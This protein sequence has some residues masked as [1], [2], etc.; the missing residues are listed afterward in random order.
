MQGS[1]PDETTPRQAARL[2]AESEGGQPL[3]E[4]EQAIRRAES[5]VNLVLQDVES[6]TSIR[7][8]SGI[9]PYAEWIDG[10]SGNP[11]TW[12]SSRYRPEEGHSAED[13]GREEEEEE[14]GDLL[15]ACYFNGT[16]FSFLGNQPAA[17]IVADIAF[18]LQDLVQR[19]VGGAWPV[20]PQHEHPMSP[21]VVDAV[22]VWQCPRDP[23]ISR[24]V[25]QLE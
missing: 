14:E 4:L 2:P 11:E 5:A 7:L 22:A 24:P 19:E 9:L 21:H 8:S 1:D 3:P 20:C 6:T 18:R 23:A 25:G 17:E 10:S 12:V 15:L 16:S 13:D